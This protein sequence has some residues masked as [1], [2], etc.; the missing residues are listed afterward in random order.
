LPKERHRKKG[1]IGNVG[2]V[3]FRGF[4]GNG[5]NGGNGGIRGIGGIEENLAAPSTCHKGLP[6]TNQII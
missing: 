4:V 5:G 2:F 1:R 6:K 3:G